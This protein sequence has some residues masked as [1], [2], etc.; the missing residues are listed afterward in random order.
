MRLIFL[1]WIAF[2]YPHGD[3]HEQINALTTTIQQFPDST[4]LYLDRGELYLLDENA[5][6]A[7]SDFSFCIRSGLITARTFVGLSKSMAPLGLRDSSLYFADKALELDPI[8]Y[9]ALECKGAL[10]LLMERYCESAEIYSRLISLASQPS[11]ALYIDASLATQQCPEKSSNTDQVLLEG[12]ARLGRLHVLEKS[13]VSIYLEEKRYTEALQVQTEIIA[14]WAVK[15]RPLY[16]R[17][18]IYL[19]TGNKPAAIADLK[20]ALQSLDSLPSYK[21]ATPAMQEMRGKIIL[22][23]NQTGS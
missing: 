5:S 8:Y 13:L 17:A 18:E 19:L 22:L 23:L 4:S 9:P 6:A 11:P 12:M 3:V 10:L 14:H 15:T 1:L 2:A 21:S 16:E 20:N 7:Q